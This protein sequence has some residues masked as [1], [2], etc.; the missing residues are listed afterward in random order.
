MLI[1][2]TIITKIVTVCLFLLIFLILIVPETYSQGKKDSTKEKKDSTKEEGLS[3]IAYPF[4]FYTPETELAFGAGG[5]IS[6][7][8][9]DKKKNPKLSSITASGY[10]T[11]NG[12]FSVSVLPELYIGKYE[13]RLSGRVG[14][15]K[16]IDKFYGIGNSVETFDSADYLQ[17]NLIITCLI[18]MRVFDDRFKVG[19]NYEFRDLSMNDKK[20][21]PFLLENTVTGSDG[22][23]NSGVGISASWDSRDD[24][25]YPTTGGF[26]EVV[27]TNFFKAFGS[28]FEYSKFSFDLRRFFKMGKES[29]IGMQFYLLS[30]NK[31]PPFYDL[32]LLGNDT[33]MR[34]YY[35]GRYRDKTYY[36]M[37]TEYRIANVFW[38]FGFVA[39]GGFGD[40][41]PSVSKITISTVKP[42]YGFGLRFR[43]DEKEKLDLR[44]DLGLGKGTSGV[45]FGAKQVF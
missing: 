17:N 45:Y 2:K 21:N 41:A 36:T 42:T 20:S 19:L 25:F 16:A 27:G 38:K 44:V 7:N 32:A 24:V 3:W 10:Y 15:D 30:E 4:A 39:F 35:T 34:G 40:V 29:T 12:Q 43:F 5:L 23:R 28:S 37:Q 33:K 22:G 8:L 9:S 18:Q 31:T 11:T 26:Y 1:I 14:Y 6:F 13:T